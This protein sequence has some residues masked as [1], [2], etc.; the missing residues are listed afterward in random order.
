MSIACQRWCKRS[1]FPLV[2]HRV[3]TPGGVREHV[4]QIGKVK[5]A[6]IGANPL[7]R[8]NKIRVRLIGAESGNYQTLGKGAREKAGH[9]QQKVYHRSIRHISRF[10]GLKKKA[11]RNRTRRMEWGRVR[12]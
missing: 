4:R 2:E 8:K 6:D 7:N 12:V 9:G 3:S 5:G 1:S 11:Q 10:W